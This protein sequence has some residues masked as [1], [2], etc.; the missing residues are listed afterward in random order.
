M[1]D[2]YNNITKVAKTASRM[3]SYKFMTKV[4]NKN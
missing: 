4:A 2:G 1:I 3:V